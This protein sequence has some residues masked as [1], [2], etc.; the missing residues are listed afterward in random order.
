MDALREELKIRHATTEPYFYDLEKEQL[1]IGQ[2]NRDAV[3]RIIAIYG[4]EA[5]PHNAT[6]EELFNIIEDGDEGEL[7]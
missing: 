2:R 4:G 1:Q 7:S 6:V 5:L 3:F